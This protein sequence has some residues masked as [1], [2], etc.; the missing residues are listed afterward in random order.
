MRFKR[1]FLAFP[2]AVTIL[3]TSSV[4][5]AAAAELHAVTA[6]AVAGGG[7]R[8]TYFNHDHNYSGCTY[9]GWYDVRYEIN[10]SYTAGSSYI[11]INSVRE[12]YY[13]HWGGTDGG[14]V[15]YRI[16]LAGL[17]RSVSYE[18]QS[19]V[20]SGQTKSIYY[21]VDPNQRFKFASWA[22]SFSVIGQAIHSLTW[23]ETCMT[24]DYS[25]FTKP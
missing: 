11:T 2:M 8:T 22:G 19:V 17:D 10:Y 24:E 4:G 5:I 14:I 21:A 13:S 3:L 9:T 25:N 23:S 1:G 7:T 16:I 6:P 12:T 20:Y 15:S 18:V